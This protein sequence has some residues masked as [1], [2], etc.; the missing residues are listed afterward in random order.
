MDKGR[1]WVYRRT[2]LRRTSLAMAVLVMLALIGTLLS[3]MPAALAQSNS[4]ATGQPTISGTTQVGQTLT[5]GTSSITD[6]NGLTNVSYGYQWV[7]GATTTH[8]DISGATG[9]TYLVTADEVGKTLK[10]RVSFTDD[11]GNDESLTSAPTAVVPNVGICNRSKQVRE[12]LVR[13]I[14][15]AQDCTDV[16]DEDL[17][18]LNTFWS[19]IHLG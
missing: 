15:T 12:K 5:A 1:T 9:T 11:A 14:S 19:C 17:A 16:S 18:G 2:I 10:V 3:D 13:M 8:T 4:P 7:A 6:S